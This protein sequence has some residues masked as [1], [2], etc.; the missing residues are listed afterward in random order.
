MIKITKKVSLSSSE[1]E[2]FALSEAVKEV[3]IVVQLLQNMKI[4]V[5]YPAACC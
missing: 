3:M 5:K 1:A 2:Y 4:V